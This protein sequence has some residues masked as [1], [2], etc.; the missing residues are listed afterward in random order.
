MDNFLLYDLFK[1]LKEN[2]K[3]LKIIKICY[4]DKSVAL[5]CGNFLVNLIK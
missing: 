5:P 4:N 2:K 1:V 3:N